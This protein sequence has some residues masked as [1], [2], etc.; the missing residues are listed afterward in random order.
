MLQEIE[1]VILDWIQQTFRCGF[2]DAVFP[3]LTLIGEW[4]AVW[5]VIALI[6]ICVKKTRKAGLA[7]LLGLVIMFLVGN[8]ALKH[9]ISRPRPC[10][11]NTNVDV[12]I[13]MPKDFSFPSGHAFS[14]FTAVTILM[15]YHKGIGIPAIFLAVILSFTRLYLYV[16]FPTDIIGGLILGILIGVITCLIVDAIDRKTGHKGARQA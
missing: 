11:I 2:L 10:W 8:V 15:H 6:M 5:I 13:A 3:K 1:F 4:G 14:A 16:H 12:L 9:L 7:V